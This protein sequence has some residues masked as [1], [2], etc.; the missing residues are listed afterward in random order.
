MAKNGR[1]YETGPNIRAQSIETLGLD[2]LN[3]LIGAKWDLF[4][5]PSC[6]KI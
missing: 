3:Y 6:Q 1:S 5:D 2:F 4:K